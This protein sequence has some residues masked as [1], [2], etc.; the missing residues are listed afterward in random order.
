MGRRGKGGWVDTEAQASVTGVVVRRKD[1]PSSAGCHDRVNRLCVVESN[2][3]H[4]GL[5]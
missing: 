2:R 5:L 1:K 3:Y 4:Y